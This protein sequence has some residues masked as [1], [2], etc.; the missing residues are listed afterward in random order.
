MDFLFDAEVMQKVAR[1]ERVLFFFFVNNFLTP[2]ETV[3]RYMMATMS[4]TGGRIFGQCGS[5]QK[6]VGPSLA[7]SGPGYLTFLNSHYSALRF[8]VCCA[9]DPAICSPSPAKGRYV[10][11]SSTPFSLFS[12]VPLV[13]ILRSC[14]RI[15]ASK[16][17]SPF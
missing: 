11:G 14:L 15:S 4:F 16:G 1:L 8:F 9:F 5:T 7:S 17:H 3:C 2:V 13:S 10:E 12:I 6:I